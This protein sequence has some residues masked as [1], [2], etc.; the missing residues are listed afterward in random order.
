[1]NQSMMEV[2]LDQLEKKG[3]NRY[4]AVLM[5]AQEA[6][7]INDQI[8]LGI[9]KSEDKPTTAALK[10]LFDGRVVENEINEVEG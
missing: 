10:R 5:A 3:I 7:F 2:E 4:K 8:R 6:R 9:I 1:M